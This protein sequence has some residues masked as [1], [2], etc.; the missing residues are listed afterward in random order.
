VDL[1]LIEH[2]NTLDKKRSHAHRVQ[3]DLV[4]KKS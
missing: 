3:H 2:N 1:K 4:K